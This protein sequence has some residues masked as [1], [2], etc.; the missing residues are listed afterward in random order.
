M[1]KCKSSSISSFFFKYIW[2]I[3]LYI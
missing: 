1:G 3:T 2:Y